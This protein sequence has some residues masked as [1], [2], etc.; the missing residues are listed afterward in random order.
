MPTAEPEIG[1]SEEELRELKCLIHSPTDI[2]QRYD[3]N[4]AENGQ[5]WYNRVLC[6]YK[7]PRIK[8]NE[9]FPN[10]E[11]LRFVGLLVQRRVFSIM[12]RHDYERHN[13]SHVVP[14]Y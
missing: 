4:A 10:L 5:T 8:R 2:R 6:G 3:D 9:V 13:V 12:Q 1:H 11:T 7:Q 14:E